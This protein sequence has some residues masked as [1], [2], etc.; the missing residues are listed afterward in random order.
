MSIPAPPVPVFPP[1]PCTLTSVQGLEAAGVRAGI[2]ASGNPDVALLVAAEPMRGVGLF[3]QNHFAAAPVRLSR[4]HL[5][6]SG[7]LVRAVVVNSGNANACTGAQGD[8]DA[9]EMCARVASALGCPVEQVLVCSTGVIGVKLPM[10]KVRAGIDQALA[11]RSADEAAGRRFLSA[12]MTT[13]AFPKEAGARHGDATVAG[14]CKGAGMIQP[15]MAT[16]LAFLATDYALPGA[17]LEE[18]VRRI[19]ATSFN[20]VHVDT[21]TST[22]DTFLVLST[23]RHPAPEG[24][25]AR[26]EAVARR[27]AWLIARDGE[28]ATKVTTIRVTGAGSDAVARAVATHVA[29]SGLVRTAL[30][31]NDPNWGRFVS[32]VGNVRGLAAPQRLVCRLQGLEVFRAGEPTPFDRAAASQA[33]RAEDVSLELQLDEGDGQAVLMTSDLG[34]RYVEVNAEYTT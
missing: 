10:E 31:G 4:R 6:A 8:A 34:Y 23:Q 28:G 21:H 2:K 17:G 14:V 22:N 13:D 15:D 18:A 32:Q 19:A 16:M 20:A 25:E 1:A 27:L 5:S 9:L 26:L 12:I 29:A 33:M 11:E 3:T 7:G 24:W 30:F